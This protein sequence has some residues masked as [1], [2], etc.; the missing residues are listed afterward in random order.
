M[1]EVRGI[2]DANDRRMIWIALVLVIAMGLSTLLT[3]AHSI[4]ARHR[5]LDNMIENYLGVEE[6]GEIENSAWDY[7]N[8]D[9][10]FRYS[11]HIIIAI[12][13]ITVVYLMGRVLWSFSKTDK[14]VKKLVEKH[15]KR[16]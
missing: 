9:P 12:M 5:A 4:G 14:L 15:R 11:P 6:W 1:D 8:D 3:A 7:Y 13:V 2:Y 16:K 10:A